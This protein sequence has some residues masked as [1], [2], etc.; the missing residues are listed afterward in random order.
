MR[1]TTALIYSLNFSNLFRVLYSGEKRTIF[2]VNVY[3]VI[4]IYSHVVE[5]SFNF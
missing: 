2:Y 1:L 3:A 5:I 4:T